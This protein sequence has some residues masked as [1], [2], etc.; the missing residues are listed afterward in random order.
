MQ[1]KMKKQV[2]LFPY[3]GVSQN[4][5]WAVG[6]GMPLQVA[7]G[8][9]LPDVN[10]TCLQTVELGIYLTDGL[11]YTLGVNKAYEILTGIQAKE[12]LGHHMSEL[13]EAGYFD[14]SVTLIVLRTRKTETI[15]QKI[16][17]NN[18]TVVVTGNPVFNERGEIVHVMTTVRPLVPG[19]ERNTE[20]NENTI[21]VPGA[22]RVI[23]A[24]PIMRD[25]FQ[26][27]M[28]V[29]HYD[30][31]V[32]I[33][34]PSGSGK[35]VVARI[36]H[37]SG[38]Y[39]DGPFVRV[40]IAAI[41]EELV[42][43]ELFGYLPGAFTGAKREGKK[44]LILAANKGTLF[45]DEIGEMS[46][47]TQVKLLRVL[48]EREVLPV[49]AT[50]PIPVDIRVV[51][52]SN[53]DLPH[54][55]QE[56]SFR[57]DLYY[58]LNVINLRVPSLAERSEDVSYLATHFLDE[59]GKRYGVYKSLRN[60]ALAQLKSYSWPGNV[61]ELQ[62]VMERLVVLYPG[63]VISG[64]QIREQLGIMETTH[65]S[66]N[67]G[68]LQKR[69]ANLEKEMIIRAVQESGGSKEKAAQILGIHR[70]TLLR[71]IQKYRL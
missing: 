50:E 57:E 70:T 71:K 13:V 62:N 7:S 20:T 60:S 46:R 12:V 24:S 39:R 31:S 42:E 29:A 14:R 25:L 44:G 53:R 51:A 36:L 23:A 1:S 45:L 69:I 41:P 3:R 18:Q 37:F 5:E 11:G 32:L 22:G 10:R 21:D 9:Y 26:R 56:G 67:E 19:G 28:R 30:S 4:M 59:L 15:R 48:Q 2:L 61:R 17:R 54:M 27:A 49:G 8:Y 47:K 38:P 6:Q 68:L 16:S 58:R 33:Q 35:E 40:N 55:V 64:E 66:L 52:A 34:G 63:T 65:L 43:S